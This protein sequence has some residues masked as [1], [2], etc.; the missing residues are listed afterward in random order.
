MTDWSEQESAL[1]LDRARYYVPYRD[2]QIALVTALVPRLAHATEVIDLGCGE[3]LL[4]EAILAA[5]PD[6]TVLALDG[7]AAMRE[8]AALRMRSYGARYRAA[9]CE[10]EQFVP[11]A[12]APRRAI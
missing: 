2:R 8:A 6:A 12:G 7:S 3:G 10:L 11:P 5:Q 1:F 9:P 4:G